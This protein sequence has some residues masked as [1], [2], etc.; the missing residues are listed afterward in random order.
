MCFTR[1]RREQDVVW[2]CFLKPNLN[3]GASVLG[4][5]W[6]GFSGELRRI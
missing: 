3:S 1:Q 4:V 5:N 2:K 6:L